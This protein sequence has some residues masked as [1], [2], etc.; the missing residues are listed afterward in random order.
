MVKYNVKVK[1]VGAKGVLVADTLSRLIQS[2]VDKTIPG[3][4]VTIAQVLSVNLSRL[5]SLQEDT[6]SDPIL[7]QLQDFIRSGW[8]ESMQDL[9]MDL[10]AFWCYRDEL[11]MLDG[12]V[13]KSNRILVPTSM[14]E[15]TLERLHEGHHGQSSMLR[16]ARRTVFWPKIQDDITRMVDRCPECQIHANKIPR[17]P[18]RQISASRPL[19]I[20]G[21]DLMEFKGQHALV[22][23]DYYSGYIFYDMVMGQTS[24]DIIT[25]L[26]VN[27][28]KF[29]PAERIISDNGPCF[30]SEEFRKFCEKLEVKHDTSSPHYHESPAR[31]K[32][33]R[34]PAS[35]PQ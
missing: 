21:V 30:K 8:P 6:K 33:L 22:S 10:H 29:W 25:T 1:Y 35:A 27:F 20:L 7:S 16:R 31:S 15:G 2:G 17:A 32:N 18:E 4:D 34:R 9:P 19:E 14:R 26:N 23:V 5:E 11:V 24:K 28:R 12:L 3:L 13:M